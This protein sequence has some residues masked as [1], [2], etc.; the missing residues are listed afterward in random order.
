MNEWCAKRKEKKKEKYE[1]DARRPAQ[2][3]FNSLFVTMTVGLR[4]SSS[5]RVE[6]ARVSRNKNLLFSLWTNEKWSS[7]IVCVCVCP[8]THSTSNLRLIRPLAFVGYNLRTRQEKKKKVEEERGG[9]R[10]GIMF[11]PMVEEEG[12]A[13]N[14]INENKRRRGQIIYCSETWVKVSCNVW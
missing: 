11:V 9:E 8:P 14:K 3:S 6:I 13:S 7:S 5:I 4:S 10:G 12:I 2:L 1:N